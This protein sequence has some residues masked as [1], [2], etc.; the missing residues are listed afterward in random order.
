M[1]VSC[2]MK[3]RHGRKINNPSEV[4]SIIWNFEKHP[5]RTYHCESDHKTRHFLEHLKRVTPVLNKFKSSLKIVDV[6]HQSKLTVSDF[7]LVF[8][9]TQ[10]KLKDLDLSK[11]NAQ[12]FIKFN[13]MKNQALIEY[14]EL[15][16]DL[17]CDE[18]E[19]N[20]DLVFVKY[21]VTRNRVSPQVLIELD[22]NKI[23]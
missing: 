15:M 12:M 8:Q 4:T 23:L 21:R 19:P 13:R 11:M 17:Q 2:P 1:D 9:Q 7:I 10:T 14:K 18:L 5:I 3:W 6:I 16:H 20:E 22:L